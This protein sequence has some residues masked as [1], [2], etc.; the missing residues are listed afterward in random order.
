MV[1]EVLSE[2]LDVESES[3]MVSKVEMSVI[4][5]VSSGVGICSPTLD[6]SGSSTNIPDRRSGVS[7]TRA[8]SAK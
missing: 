2:S 3:E 5:V 4:V 8:E 7:G 1:G 6:T